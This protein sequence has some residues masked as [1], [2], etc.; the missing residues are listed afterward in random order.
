MKNFLISGPP[1]SGKSI[2]SRR[3]AHALGYSYIPGDAIVSSFQCIFPEHGISHGGKNYTQIAKN[4]APFLY[5]LISEL[6]RFKINFVID[7][8]HI[9]P[10][11]L[12]NKLDRESIE[13]VFIGYGSTTLEEKM[14]AI[15]QYNGEPD[16]SKSVKRELMLPKLANWIEFSRNLEKE[17]D[18]LGIRYIDLGINFEKSLT[19]AV[20][21][22]FQLA[23]TVDSV[24]KFD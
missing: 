7:S 6:Q 18:S 20:T 21:L 23:D 15:E 19:A 1:R 5:K 22:L 16:W 9:L 3:L 24:V 8:Y 17:C 10:H 14:D 2:L 4:F 11:N 12:I 13:V